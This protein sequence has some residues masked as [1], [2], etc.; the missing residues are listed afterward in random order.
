MSARDRGARIAPESRC[1]E[2]RYAM[3]DVWRGLACLLVVFH[4]AG[5]S[6][7]WSEIQGS[8]A[9]WLTVLTLRDMNLGVSLFFVISGYCIAAS[10]ESNR[11]R[12]D[13][14]WSFLT[15]RLWR[16][17]PPYWAAMLAFAAIVLALDVYGLDRLHLPRRGVQLDSPGLLDWGQ[18]LGNFT[19]TET[20]RP[21]FWGSDRN[22]YTAV[23]WSLCFEEQFYMICFLALWLIPQRLALAFGGATLVITLIRVHAWSTGQ[24]SLLSGT[25]PLLWHEFAVG[26]AVYYRLVHVRSLEARRL[27]DGAILGLLLIGLATR[28][29]E[30]SAAAAFGLALIALRPWD[31]ALLT[32][33]SL[34]PLAACGRRCYSIYLIHLPIVVVGNQWLYNLGLTGFWTRVLV[35]IPL[36]SAAGIASGWAFHAFVE[37]R[38]QNL[39]AN[40]QARPLPSPPPV[41]QRTIRVRTTS[42][43]T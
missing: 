19:L 37:S 27:I 34:A 33:P 12:S 3:L 8:G 38:F 41:R 32:L 29:L 15:R 17:Y 21:H 4:H 43:V 42:I 10:A 25:F 26:L 31:A 5:Q 11:R 14:P 1:W 2:P 22:V 39:A 28:G 13:P 20:W 7:G 6:L 30:T 18:W 35:S 24:L 36:V 23:A 16:I 9:R 40:R